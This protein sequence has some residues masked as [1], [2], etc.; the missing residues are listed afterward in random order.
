MDLRRRDE[1]VCVIRLA[2]NFGLQ[3]ALA[4]CHARARTAEEG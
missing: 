3:A 4:A 1:R 2:R